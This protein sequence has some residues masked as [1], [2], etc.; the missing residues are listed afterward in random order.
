MNFINFLKE[1][2]P[3]VD[4]INLA[5]QMNQPGAGIKNP[6]W[7]THRP[8]RAEFEYY[9]VKPNS[10]SGLAKGNAK[11]L[12]LIGLCGSQRPPLPYIPGLMYFPGPDANVVL[13]TDTQGFV[14]TE[15]SLRWEREKPGLIVYE[16]CVKSKLRQLAPQKVKD[17]VDAAAVILMGLILSGVRVAP[18]AI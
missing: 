1:N 13:W 8:A 3:T 11:I 6:D 9:E 7:M 15:V 2:N 16:V 18:A 12:F 4:E 17:A 14:Q 5:L 10:K